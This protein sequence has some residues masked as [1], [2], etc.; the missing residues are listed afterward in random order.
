[1]TFEG[2]ATERDQ[3]GGW[4]RL[5]LLNSLLNHVPSRLYFM[6]VGNS[7]RPITIHAVMS[8]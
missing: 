2:S 8:L 1:M 5:Y 7:S 6:V 3:K 4:N